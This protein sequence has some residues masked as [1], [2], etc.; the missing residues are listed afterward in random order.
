MSLGEKQGCKIQCNETKNSQR[1]RWLLYYT[2]NHQNVKRETQLKTR[3]EET[4]KIHGQIQQG[5][6]TSID[7]SG[8]NLKY[9]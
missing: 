4:E 7:S 8:I 2:K 5:Y 1:K 6:K 3:R 9:K